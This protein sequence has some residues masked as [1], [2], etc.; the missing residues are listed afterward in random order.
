MC[1]SIECCNALKSA[2]AMAITLSVLY[3]IPMLFLFVGHCFYCLDGP[4]ILAEVGFASEMPLFSLPR[5][6]LYTNMALLNHF[7]PLCEWVKVF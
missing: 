1:L 4:F 5:S 7:V 6:W 3:G 2:A